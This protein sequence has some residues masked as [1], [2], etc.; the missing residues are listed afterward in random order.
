MDILYYEY[1]LPFPARK[2]SQLDLKR[3]HVS[4]KQRYDYGLPFVIVKFARVPTQSDPQEHNTQYSMTVAPAQW[5]SRWLQFY[6]VHAEYI[7]LFIILFTSFCRAK[8]GLNEQINIIVRITQHTQCHERRRIPQSW[9]IRMQSRIEYSAIN[10]HVSH[11]SRALSNIP[12]SVS[13]HVELL[14]W[15]WRAVWLMNVLKLF[16]KGLELVHGWNGKERSFFTICH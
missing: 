10:P 7:F 1:G 4:K 2:K 13:L 9:V 8:S 14:G 5:P 12:D 16:M 3:E 15:K 11:Y 6:A